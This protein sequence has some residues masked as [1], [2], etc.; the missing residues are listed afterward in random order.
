MVIQLIPTADSKAEIKTKQSTKLLYTC[1]VSSELNRTPLLFNCTEC[2]VNILYFSLQ[3]PT[4]LPHFFDG[5][6]STKL[7]C[8]GALP[9]IPSQHLPGTQSTSLCISFFSFPRPDTQNSLYKVP[10]TVSF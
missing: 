9:H 1:P 8:L 6:V 10:V 3:K 7:S 5:D 4:P 2:Y